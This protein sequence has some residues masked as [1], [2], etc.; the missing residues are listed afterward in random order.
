MQF[1]YGL[2]VP[3]ALWLGG[4]QVIQGTLQVGDLTKVILYLMAIGHRIGM[5]GQV[6]NIVQNASASAERILEIIREP[7]AIK[8]GK[9][10][11]PVGRGEVRPD[12]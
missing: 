8:S 12:D 3:L 10:A 1:I 7:Q 6:T 5:V 4:R 2:S 11:L 9:R